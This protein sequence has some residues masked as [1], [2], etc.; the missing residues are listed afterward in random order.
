[1]TEDGRKKKQLKKEKKRVRTELK[2]VFRY[3]FDHISHACAAKQNNNSNTS[4]T[5]ITIRLF[6]I[7]LYQIYRIRSAR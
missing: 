5:G 1:V 7:W 6:P 4:A 2:N 3:Q